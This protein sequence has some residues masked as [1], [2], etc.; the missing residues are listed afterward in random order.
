MARV[1]VETVDHVARLAHLTLTAEERETFARHLAQVLEYA[2]TLQALDTTDIPLMNNGDRLPIV[3]SMACMTGWYD[4]TTEIDLTGSYVAVEVPPITNFYPVATGFM[5]EWIPV[6][7]FSSVVNYTPNLTNSFS[8][9][10][11]TLP[12]PANIYT[13]TVHGADSKC[14][15]RVDLEP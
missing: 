13:D 11:A 9:L 4:N 12:Y 7:G 6:A 3:L 8:P 2:E 15:Y 10:S 5:L 14:F 1:T